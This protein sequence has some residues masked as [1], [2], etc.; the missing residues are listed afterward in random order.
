MDPKTRPNYPV[1]PQK[2]ALAQSRHTVAADGCWVTTYA[3]NASTGYATISWQHEGRTRS[4]TVHR[5]SFTHSNGPIPDGMVVDHMCHNRLCVN[6]AHLRLLT[7]LQNNIRRNNSG[8]HDFPLDT[9]QRGHPLSMMKMQQGG[10]NAGRWRRCQGCLKENNDVLTIMNTQ[11]RL[12]EIAYGMGGHETK[13][14]Y[15]GEIRK[16]EARI[17]AVRIE[18]EGRAA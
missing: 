17:E 18:R 6:P 5:A 1:P 4:T 2:A 3:L 12:L 9:C 8:A 10:K 7:L 13:R 14:T 15:A 11:L 16:R